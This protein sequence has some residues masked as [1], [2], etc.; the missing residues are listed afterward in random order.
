MIS[1]PFSFLPPEVANAI[2]SSRICEFVTLSRELTPLDT[3]LLHFVNDD[4]STSEVATGLAYPVKA[5]RAR[6]NN[7]VALLLEGSDGKGGSTPTVMIQALSSVRDSDIQANLDLYA[8]RCLHIMLAGIQPGVTW[9]QVE[10]AVW[11]WARIW[12]QCTPVRGVWWAAGAGATDLPTRWEAPTELRPLPSDPPPAAAGSKAPAW[13][14]KEW[15]GRAQELIAETPRPHLSLVDGEFP[16]VARTHRCVVTSDGFVM[17][18]PA[19]LPGDH[20]GVATLCFNG[21]GTFVGRVQPTSDGLVMNVERM[22]P[23]LPIVSSGVFTPTDE[24]R[25]QLLDRLDK[26]LARRGQSRPVFREPRPAS[27]TNVRS[28]R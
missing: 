8:R 21:R 16:S 25:A 3:P 7:K 28:E 18:V 17:D 12:I 27:F 13:P 22:L 14:V 24:A 10:E 6:R 5:E 26:E 19:G 4:G 2:T 20:H 15:R 11:Y 1:N 23:D 9:E